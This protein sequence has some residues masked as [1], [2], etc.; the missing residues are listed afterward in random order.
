MMNRKKIVCISLCLAALFTGS[1]L[2]FFHLD[3]NLFSHSQEISIR[4]IDVIRQLGNVNG[5]VTQN[6]MLNLSQ[7]PNLLANMG[8]E[9]ILPIGAYLLTLVLIAITFLFILIDKF[10]KAI[11][12]LLSI[13]LV[14]AIYAGYGISA[15]PSTLGSELGF[16]TAFIDI[17]EVIHLNLG[18][19]Y[20]IMVTLVAGLLCINLVTKQGL[21]IV[22]DKFTNTLLATECE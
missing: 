19:G 1:V 15:L 20:F 13:S 4:L 8:T 7:D 9:S 17:S 14:S 3:F 21:Q 12:I 18:S 16:L 5:D 22:V 11:W 10:E 2:P 6:G